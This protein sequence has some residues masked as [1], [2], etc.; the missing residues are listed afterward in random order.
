VQASADVSVPEATLPSTPPPS[1]GKRAQAWLTCQATV[2]QV[3]DG[4][5]L[6]CLADVGRAYLP[7]RVRLA[8]VNAPELKSADAGERERARAAA[9]WLK[10][11][12]A[13]LPTKGFPLTL[14]VY[15]ADDWDRWVAEV[16]LP[17]GTN[18]SDA[19][20][21]AG[22]ARPYAPRLM[23][24]DV[25]MESMENDMTAQNQLDP[26]PQPIPPAPVEP[27]P[28]APPGFLARALGPTA[29]P[30]AGNVRAIIAILGVVALHGLAVLL[31]VRNDPAYRDATLAL[32][33]ALTA[34]DVGFASSYF[35]KRQGDGA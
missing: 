17:D 21:A 11:T 18:L 28:P 14:H 20:L 31:L 25:S 24:S 7:V 13:A 26:N 30:S 9:A 19:L 3:V 10:Q 33:S 22:H 32:L 29:G 23:Q 1:T 2:Q 4:D 6:R 16:E 35:G 34:A 8:R 27:A 15:G 5:T 12:L